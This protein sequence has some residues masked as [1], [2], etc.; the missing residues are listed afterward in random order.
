MHEQMSN[1]WKSKLLN[2]TALTIGHQAFR[3]KVREFQPNTLNDSAPLSTCP[4]G[5]VPAHAIMPKQNSDLGCAKFILLNTQATNQHLQFY[6]VGLFEAP[7]FSFPSPNSG[8]SPAQTRANQTKPKLIR[9]QNAAPLTRCSAISFPQL[10]FIENQK[11]WQG[12]GNPATPMDPWC[13]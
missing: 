10:R 1:C 2:P 7:F 9:H 4:I 12:W 6:P 5:Y 13:I 3:Q 8:Y 11:T